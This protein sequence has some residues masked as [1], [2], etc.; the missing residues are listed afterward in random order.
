VTEQ[1]SEPSSEAAWLGQRCEMAVEMEVAIVE[2]SLQPCEEL[3]AEDAAEHLDG[4]EERPARSD[5]AC[6]VRS[7]AAG[8]DHAVDMWMVLEA[9][10]PGV[11]HAEEADLCA[12]VPWVTSNLLQRRGAGVEEKAVDH[13]LVLKCQRSQ[14]TRQREH[15]V[16]VA[17]RQQLWFALLKPA[18]ASVAL[19][20]RAMP[21]AARVIGDGGISAT[22]ALIAV[23]AERGG[24]ATYDRLQ[25]LQVLTVDPAM[26]A[27][28]ESRSSAANDVGHLQRGAAQALRGAVLREASASWSSGLAVALRCFC[29]RWR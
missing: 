29:E 4:K 13:S 15:G 19:A 20:S 21:V 12:E 24:A 6:V 26:T 2:R 16:D 9:L 11:E 7:E 18:Q 22:G 10:V 28:S 1:A 3:A 17:R 27:F 23:A 14:F 8:G 5:P 25:H